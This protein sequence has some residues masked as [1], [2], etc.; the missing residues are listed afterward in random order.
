[1]TKNE[2]LTVLLML[3]LMHG[4]FCTCAQN[5]ID[6]K[7]AFLH[8]IELSKEANSEY[9]IEY[10]Y[11]YKNREYEKI[12]SNEFL[13]NRSISSNQ[14]EIE[15]S[16][17]ELKNDYFIFSTGEFSEY[18]FD[19]KGFPFK[20]ALRIQLKMAPKKSECPKC[21][22]FTFL[23]LKFVNAEKINSIPM[24]SLKAYSLLIKRTKGGDI[25]RKFACKIYFKLLN[26]F[27][28][29]KNQ[30]ASFVD[31]LA[32]IQKVEILNI[33]GVEYNRGNK[34]IISTITIN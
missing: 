1:M 3:I 33:Y 27:N 24:D 20:P 29:Q 31:L 9:V 7:S 13:L 8:F 26:S 25:D 32:E 21:Q 23:D 18:D 5:V 34:G 19:T 22:T 12:R 2:R 4:S 11:C 10:I 28:A 17:T 14:R 15:K 16:V 30:Y 6:G